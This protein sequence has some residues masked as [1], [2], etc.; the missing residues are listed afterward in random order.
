[1]RVALVVVIVCA[2]VGV[3]GYFGA[4]PRKQSDTAC[5][6]TG[7]TSYVP[8]RGIECPEVLTVLKKTRPVGYSSQN[9]DI[10][11][12]KCPATGCSSLPMDLLAI[13]LEPK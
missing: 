3:A 7:W 8:N 11:M 1:M 4:A 12:F 2:V 9:E 6:A 10:L 13:L 5:F